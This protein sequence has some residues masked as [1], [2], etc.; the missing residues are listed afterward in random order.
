MGVIVSASFP[1]LAGRTAAKYPVGGEVDVHYNPRN[2]GESVLRP[3]SSLH[4]L[5]WVV[6]VALFAFAWALA[7]GRLR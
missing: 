3:R 5:L 6:A 4:H 2:P 1:G 7:T